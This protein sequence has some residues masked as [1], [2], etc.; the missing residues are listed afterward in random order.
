MVAANLLYQYMPLI[1]YALI[2]FGMLLI[3]FILVRPVIKTMK[4]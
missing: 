3:Y 4:K 1:K 2:G